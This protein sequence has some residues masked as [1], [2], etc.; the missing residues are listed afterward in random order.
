MLNWYLQSG[1]DSD[2]IVSSRI[3]LA[4][5]IS[6][7]PFETKCNETKKEEITKLIEEAIS[8]N[9]YGIKLLKLKDMDDITINSLIEK[10]LISPDFVKGKDI[11]KAILIN[12]EENVCAMI[13]TDDHISLQVFGAGLELDNLLNLIIELDEFLDEKLKFAFSEK[14]GF[15]TACPIEAGTAMKASVM[16]HVPA[17]QITGNIGKI[18]EIINNFGMNVTGIHGEGSKSEGALYQISNKQTLGISEKEIIKKIKLITDKIIEQERIARK[19]LGKNRLNFED[20][21]YRDYSIL[22][23]CRKISESECKDLLST[24][25]LGTDLGIIGELTDLKI[26]KLLL[27]TQDANLQKLL[28][29]KLEGI[30]LDAKRAEVIKTIINE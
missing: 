20:K 25:K 6:N 28:G 9:K 21:L 23:N 22:T 24:L 3:R 17:L 18:L 1:K 16:V 8:G 14:Y 7:Y 19:Y 2:V 27:Y 11:A 10:R 12:D 29:N 13:H 4:R 5:N 15:L 30:D 26:N